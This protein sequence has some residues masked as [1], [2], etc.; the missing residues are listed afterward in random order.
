MGIRR[1]DHVQLAIPAG[2]E[3]EARKFYQD[4]LGIPEIPKPEHL[5][6]RGGAWFESGNR[7]V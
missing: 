1:I 7:K 2:G 5:A 4:T 6:K 3:S